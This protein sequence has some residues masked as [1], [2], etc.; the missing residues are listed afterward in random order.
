MFGLFNDTSL[1]ARRALARARCGH[2]RPAGAGRRRVAGRDAPAHDAR[3]S[4]DP[5]PVQS[6]AYIRVAGNLQFYGTS[7]RPDSICMPPG[8]CRTYQMHADAQMLHR[9]PLPSQKSSSGALAPSAARSSRLPARGSLVGADG[10][11][12]HTDGGDVSASS[13]KMSTDTRRVS[14]PTEQ[15]TAHDPRSAARRS[16]VGASAVGALF[17]GLE[18]PLEHVLVVPDVP[19]SVGGEDKRHIRKAGPRHRRGRCS[20]R[21]APTWRRG[22]A[23]KSR[24][25]RASCRASAGRTA[26]SR[27]RPVRPAGRRARSCSPARCRPVGSQ[28]QV[29]GDRAL[30]RNGEDLQVAQ[31][32]LVVRV[33]AEE[34]SP[35][36]HRAP[37]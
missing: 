19:Q 1:G 23:C 11:E 31:D 3:R 35:S 16:A 20:S 36:L 2:P 26:P 27:A 4:H 7:H 12:G 34:F 13:P 30:V 32:L 28:A 37:R 8:F 22:T 17:H 25:E 33:V 5:Q 9:T 15:L 21:R 24:P 29:N 14:R 6:E 10:V 18:G